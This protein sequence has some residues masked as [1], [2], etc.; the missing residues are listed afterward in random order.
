MEK[1][2]RPLDRTCH[3]LWEKHHVGCV[4]D[5]ILFSLL[6]SAVDLYDIAETLK[7]VKRK[8]N[9]K[10]DFK[11]RLVE[12]PAEQAGKSDQIVPKEIIV[13]EDEQDEARGNNAYRKNCFLRPRFGPFYP[14]TSHIIHADRQK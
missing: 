13:L 8:A 3:Q 4:G 7:R 11:S 9:R 12:V 10:N 14:D 6:L 5:E 2:L 1:I